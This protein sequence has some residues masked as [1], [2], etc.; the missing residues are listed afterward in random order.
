MSRVSEIEP[1]TIVAG[2]YRVDR[3][4]GIGGMGFVVAATHLQLDQK[5]ALKFLR[6]ESLDNQEVVQRFLREARA[7]VRLRGEHVARV[8]D[9][10]VH[11]DGRPFMVMEYLEGHDLSRLLKMRGQLPVEE[12]VD[13]ILQA[14]EALAEA[15]GLGIV[16]RDLKPANLFLTRTP[17]GLPLVKVLDFGISKANP[18][19]D[20]GTAAPSITSSASMLGSPG[21]MAPEQ[22]RSS[23]D[24]DARSDIWSLGIILFRLV[25][26][27][28][29][30]QGGTLGDLLHKVM[31]EPT[32]Q[33]REF[34]PDL[35]AG[36][37]FVVEKC[38]MKHRADRFA[39]LAELAAALAP[40]ATEPARASAQRVAMVLSAAG[41]R[42][43]F[44]SG[45]SGTPGAPAVTVPGNTTNGTDI[46]RA[47]WTGTGS[48]KRRLTR[49]SVAI[50]AGAMVAT[51]AAAGLVIGAFIVRGRLVPPN[52][53]AARADVSAAP[54]SPAVSAPEPISAPAAAVPLRAPDAVN[55]TPGVRAPEVRG[56]AATDLQP[57]VRGSA[58]TDLRPEVRGSA[59]TDLQPAAR[60]AGAVAGGGEASTSG[61]RVRGKSRVASTPSSSAVAPDIP[62]T[63]E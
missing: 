44:P 37:E 54:E 60:D 42:P 24:V 22:M 25:S 35:P 62:S 23:R 5:L 4:I 50:A 1:G 53:A 10:G 27:R 30:F 14:C 11:D 29:P 7:S 8:Y 12:T 63:R 34:C 47:A 46:T 33:L 45:T 28:I 41:S 31:N 61:A 18:L 15:H 6:N 36:F 59:A 19:G 16:H 20:V 48:E 13:Y 38:L 51:L 17:A 9:V 58:A 32:P 57:E 43:S 52:A 26:G 3:V 49:V 56:S 2:K 21:Y 39:N 55:P 40:Y